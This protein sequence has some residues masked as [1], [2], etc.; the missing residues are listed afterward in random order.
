MPL[1]VLDPL[2]I[3]TFGTGKKFG[4]I[5][6]DIAGQY[7][8]YSYQYPDLFGV[9]GDVRPNFDTVNESKFSFFT[10]IKYLW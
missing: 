7:S 4:N 5:A 8:L 1:E 10:T 9:E 3:F 2:S 6:V